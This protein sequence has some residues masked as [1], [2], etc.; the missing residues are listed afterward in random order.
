MSTPRVIQKKVLH[1]RQSKADIMSVKS[2]SID[3]VKGI[4]LQKSDREG[5]LKIGDIINLQSKEDL[6]LSNLF[7]SYAGIIFGDGIAYDELECIPKQL[8]FSKNQNVQFRQSLFRVEPAY[9]YGLTRHQLLESERKAKKQLVSIYDRKTDDKNA[10]NEAELEISYGRTVTYGER[11]QL[12]HLHSNY[13]M[14]TSVNIAKEHGCLKVILTETGNEGSWIEILPCNNLRQEGEPIQYIDKFILSSRIEKSYYYLHMGIS[15]VYYDEMISELNASNTKSLWKASK[16]ISYTEIRKNPL[17]VSSGDSFRIY[18]QD[19]GG[20]LSVSSRD[21]SDLLPPDLDSE[22]EYNEEKVKCLVLL[23][24]LYSEGDE[25]KV[26]KLDVLIEKNKSG[27]SLWELERPNPFIGGIAMSDEYFRIKHVGTGMY[28]EISRAG[29]ISLKP[30]PKSDFNVFRF[31]SSSRSNSKTSSQINFNTQLLI[32]SKETGYYLGASEKEG[33]SSF[34]SVES[35]DDTSKVSVKSYKDNKQLTNT[36][37]VLIDV[38]ELSTIH[39]YQISRIVLK[40]IDFYKFIRE[41]GMLK[42]SSLQWI[43]NYDLIITTEDELKVE[44]RK[45]SKILK[46]LSERMLDENR[47][48][49]ETVLMAQETIKDT[50]LLDLLL[51]LAELINKKILW[52]NE[53]SSRQRLN[54][55]NYNPEEIEK[56]KIID[57]ILSKYLVKFVEDLYK[58]ISFCIKNNSANCEILKNYDEFLSSQFSFYKADVSLLLKETFRHS[59]DIMG[60][61]STKQFGT[62]AEQIQVISEVKGDIVDQTLIFMIFSS[63]CVYKNKGLAKY[64]ELIEMNFFDHICL[65]KILEFQKLDGH[66]FINFLPGTQTME[67]FLES[68]P[69]IYSY[70]MRANE[71]NL[72]YIPL[73]SFKG[74][75]NLVNYVAC[76]IDLL[77]NLCLSRHDSSKRKIT[78]IF[79]ITSD[80]VLS[81]IIDPDVDLKIRGSFM[82]FARAM[83]LDTDPITPITETRDRCCFWDKESMTTENQIFMVKSSTIAKFPVAELGSWLLD[84]WCKTEFPCNRIENY[85][86]GAR[87]K[88]TTELLQ[89]TICLLDLGY[90]DFDFFISIYPSLIKLIYDYSNDSTMSVDFLPHWCRTLKNDIFKLSVE[91]KN[92]MLL[93][94]L[95]IF[96]VANLI[97]KNKEI[98]A[99]MVL[100]GKYLSMDPDQ[101][102][103][104]DICDKFVEVTDSFDFTKALFKSTLQKTKKNIAGVFFLNAMNKTVPLK[105]QSSLDDSEKYQL[106]I[107]LLNLL[108]KSSNKAIKVQALD[109]I[110]EN[111]NHKKI[112]LNELDEVQL[113]YTY[114]QRQVYLAMKYFIDSLGNLFKRLTTDIE[115]INMEDQGIEMSYMETALFYF[116]NIKSL[117]DITQPKDHLLFAQNIARNLSFEKILLK[118]FLNYDLPW[119]TKK[120]KKIIV[121]RWKRV[122][123]S[124]V[125][126]LFAFSFKNIKNQ[127]LIYPNMPSIVYYFGNGIG[128]STLLSQVLSCQ[129]DYGAI[130]NIINYIFSLFNMNEKIEDSPHD[131]KMLLNLIIDEKK[132]IKSSAQVNVV[133]ALVSSPAILNY[134]TR[135]NIVDFSNYSLKDVEF[136]SAVVL[137]LANCCVNN[138]FSVKQCQRIIPYKL[139]LKEL[140]DNKINYTL[141]KAYLHYLEFAYMNSSLETVD[142]NQL[143]QLFNNVLIPDLLNFRD[144]LEY[145]PIL[146]MKEVYKTVNFR[147]EIRVEPQETGYIVRE[148][149]EDNEIYIKNPDNPTP[150]ESEALD[151][152]KYLI[153]AKPWKIEFVT[154]L[155]IFIHDLCIDMKLSNY[156]PSPSMQNHLEKVIEII[157]DIKDS[158]QELEEKYPKLNFEFLIDTISVS[159]S[160]VPTNF[161]MKMNPSDLDYDN[162]KTI[163]K[164]IA[165]LTKTFELT[166][167]KFVLDKL[168]I[169]TK[170]VN[171]NELTIKCKSFLPRDLNIS[172]IFRGLK[173]LGETINV[174]KFIEEIRENTKT[175]NFIRAYSLC[176]DDLPEPEMHLNSKIKVFISLLSSTF[177]KDNDLELNALVKQVKTNIVDVALKEKNFSNFYKFTRNLEIAFSNPNH[178]I[179]LIEIFRQMILIERNST[180]SKEEKIPRIR[181]IQQGLLKVNI[182]ELCLKYLS[183]EYNFAIVSKAF[184]LLNQLLQDCDISVKE[185]VLEEI[186]RLGLSLKIFSFIRSI[187]HQTQDG[188]LKLN[189]AGNNSENIKIDFDHICFDVFDFLKLTTSQCFVGFQLYLLEQLDADQRVSVDIVSEVTKFLHNLIDVE[190][191]KANNLDPNVVQKIVIVAFEV[192]TFFCQGPCEKNQAAVAKNPQIYSL[193]NWFTS[194]FDFSST[195][196][197]AHHKIINSI[198][199][200]LLSLLEGDGSE[201][202]AIEMLNSLK[203]E[204][205]LKIATS[206]Y[207]NNIKHQTY[208][209]SQEKPQ[210]FETENCIRIY[211]GFNITILFLK[212]QDRFPK[213]E[214]VKLAFRASSDDIDENI[215]DSE[216]YNYQEA[217]VQ[218]LKSFWNKLNNIFKSRV[219]LDLEFEKLKEAHFYYTSNISSVEIQFKSKLCQ[220]FFR[221]PPMLKFL[222]QKS[223]KDIFFKVSRKSHQEKLD[224]FFDKSKIWEFEMV[225]QQSLGRYLYLEKLISYWDLYGFIAFIFVI[226][227]NLTM[228]FSYDQNNFQGNSGDIY[229]F[230]LFCSTVQTIFA[231]LYFISYTIEYFPVIKQKEIYANYYMDESDLEKIQRIRG[232]LL[233]KEFIGTDKYENK[234]SEGSAIKFLFKDFQLVYCGIY[235]IIS[236]IAWYNLF[237]YSIL[238]LDIVKR[239]DMLINILKSISLNHRQILLT[240]ILGLFIVFMYSLIYMV[241][242]SGDFDDKY[243]CKGLSQCFFTLLNSGVRAGGGVGDILEQ[244][245]LMDAS[246]VPR[247]I[248]DLS[249][250]AIVVIVLLNIIFGIIIDTFAQLR[251]QRNEILKDMRENCFICGNSRFQLEVRRISW[252]LHVHLHHSIHSYLAFLI[253]I[254]QKNLLHCNGAEIYTKE[255]INNNDV[256]FFPRT[257]ISVQK[258]DEEFKKSQEKVYKKYLKKLEQIKSVLE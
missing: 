191:I 174:N 183:S 220:L 95:N 71:L 106:D 239:N 66:L 192:L 242:F 224:D 254:R 140:L 90:L 208:F 221:I 13:F 156:Q 219:H 22:F 87:L 23:P 50:G 40:I 167:E 186:K 118:F 240:L 91:K 80:Y 129:R 238:L 128:T 249:F 41:W 256:S 213:N 138:E 181:Q 173:T 97:R 193:I 52:K 243:Y 188:L 233:M 78:E 195:E 153:S 252:K 184:K 148:Y 53:I 47:V 132:K 21:I 36:T 154:G 84:A 133:K 216:A 178:K 43:P 182:T 146:A 237:I 162:Y 201:S 197:K 234:I 253:Y 6:H 112:V 180:D 177:K 62:W 79:N 46:G 171:I 215:E 165:A 60:K 250:F 172:Y 248:S 3:E 72:K 1:K 59:V 19:H 92:S 124:L 230:L 98:E 258:Y 246:F 131:L 145:L 212:F 70:Y 228:L 159:I 42:I 56:N 58:A 194:D 109:L 141:K 241:A 64:Q 223:R 205:L 160:E 61:I 257:S 158:V 190:Q 227:I 136:H 199:Y 2:P 206:I 143:D 176:V 76:F 179:Y 130:E 94:I 32:Q 35:Q 45:V 120:P 169:K 10:E 202:I 99:L 137:L 157:M 67:E 105:M 31:I 63:F 44:V 226:A 25:T 77:S 5:Y 235:M 88:F 101:I 189:Y 222:T 119:L 48:D 18:N 74:P 116:Q 166:P 231:I 34:L 4:N 20:Y 164:Q 125:H 232:T 33:Y 55:H 93:I 198:V 37:F 150:E 83:F 203:I 16:Y 155:I 168:K 142:Y 247:I 161:E 236:I 210:D 54:P 81:C 115:I 108:F 28:L 89:L 11:V 200:F 29:N 225:Y 14:T 229:D 121:K 126:S 26:K 8:M 185:H 17:L 251:D 134:Y 9:Q 73:A 211:I 27:R 187:L 207:Y 38:P 113:L 103:A 135:G 69:R 110:L 244:N 217:M 175:A 30:Y 147:K 104:N 152:W 107:C 151:Y 57:N 51:K 117:L 123:E 75:K 39:I 149:F 209:I 163:I 49:I 111:F 127:L 122:Y 85:S 24:K 170:E 65:I 7:T 144:Y 96:S 68:N 214:K 15:A 100:Y 86:P 82:K 114:N 218:N 196:F 204:N 255:K 139:V 102:N 12:R 245:D